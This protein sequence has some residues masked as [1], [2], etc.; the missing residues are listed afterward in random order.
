MW[1]TLDEKI[2]NLEHVQ[3]VEICNDINL[4][5]ASLLLFFVG[6]SPEN[7]VLVYTSDKSSVQFEYERLI[8]LLVNRGK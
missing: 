1:I 2:V 3:K 5:L 6:G 7:S 4:D 8:R